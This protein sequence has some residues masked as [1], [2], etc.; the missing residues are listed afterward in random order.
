VKIYLVYKI[1][2]GTCGDPED[3]CCAEHV[4]AY[5]KKETAVKRV[6][7]LNRQTEFYESYDLDEVVIK[8]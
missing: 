3:W 7:E 5:R 4:E 6:E 8:D 1:W 2:C